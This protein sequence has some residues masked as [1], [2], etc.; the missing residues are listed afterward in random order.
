MGRLKGDDLVFIFG[1]MKPNYH[2]LLRKDRIWFAFAN[3]EEGKKG[4][5]ILKRVYSDFYV[6]SGDV[7]NY[8]DFNIKFSSEQA[9]KWVLDDIKDSLDSYAE[10]H[11]DAGLGDF[12][13]TGTDVVVTETAVTK[14]NDWT[15]YLV[16]GA[17]AVIILLLIWDKLKK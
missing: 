10:Y 16:I 1:H 5:D 3:K 11:H 2:Q 14:K 17:V 4:H 8:T 13:G 7:L 15:A 12:A 6:D 9:A